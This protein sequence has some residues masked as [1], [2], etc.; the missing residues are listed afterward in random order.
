MGPGAI[1]SACSGGVT[2]FSTPTGT[3]NTREVGAV[4]T[5]GGCRWSRRDL[6][7]VG[8]CGSLLPLRLLLLV[9]L[10]PGG[11][12]PTGMDLG[13]KSNPSSLVV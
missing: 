8:V 2:V 3:S 5:G 6:P 13:P 1:G 9:C 12:C 7:L 10:G 4:R 11:A